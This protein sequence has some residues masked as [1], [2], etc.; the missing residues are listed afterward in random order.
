MTLRASGSWERGAGDVVE[1]GLSIGMRIIMLC[2]FEGNFGD[3]TR[4]SKVYHYLKSTNNDVHLL[5]LRSEHAPRRRLLRHPSVVTEVVWRKLMREDR[6]MLKDRAYLNLGVKVVSRKLRRITPD[7]IWAE[8]VMPS[9]IALTATRASTPVVAN[10]HGI[11]SAEYEEDP[12]ANVSEERVRFLRSV[13][14]AVFTGSTHCIAV[15]NPMKEHMVK[16]HNIDPRK[17]TVIPNG[18]DIRQKVSTWHDPLRVIYGGIF[19]FWEDID[20]YLDLAKINQVCEFYLAGKGPLERSI[21]HRIQHERIM[22]RH[23]GYLT[24][25]GSVEKF[26]KMNVGVAPSVSSTTRRVAC[27]VKIF[28]YLS[29]GLPV[30]TPNFGE[31]ASVVSTNECGFVTESSDGREFDECLKRVDRDTWD[32]MSMNA[33]RL[34]KEEFNWDL[35]LKR[36]DVVLEGL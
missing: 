22:V 8:N 19:K 21:L 14:N 16:T 2:D 28:D 17:I 24:H 11:V 10:I 29:C 34:I 13:E 26:S 3:Y 4:T 33:L 25:R 23:L 15:S 31:W 30:I 9:L 20:S 27:P 12:L 32:R 36:I 1:G 18:S 5:N 35:L 6:Q 7:L